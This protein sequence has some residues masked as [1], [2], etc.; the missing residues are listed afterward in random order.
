MPPAA[1]DGVVELVDMIVVAAVD[2]S[3]GGV[4]GVK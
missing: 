4:K 1:A 2:H 3:G